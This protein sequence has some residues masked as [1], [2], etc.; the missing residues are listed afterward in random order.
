M[1]RHTGKVLWSA[2]AKSGFRHNGT[3]IGGG[4]LYTID[5]LSG[6]QEAKLKRRGEEPPFPPRLIAFDLKTGQELWSTKADVFGTFLSYSDRHDGLVESGR[7]AR[8]TLFDEPDGMRA[9]AA[10]SGAVLWHDKDY[11]GPA[12]I[13]GDTILQGYTGCD[14]LTGAPKK[15]LDP[16]T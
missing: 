8:A 6:E 11:F 16:L 3:C 15:R 13:H 4:R 12:M 2:S 14:L 1:N 5:R 9:Y 10:K 7:Y